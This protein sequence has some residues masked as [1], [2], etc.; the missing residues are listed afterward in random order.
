M[1]YEGSFIVIARNI[2]QPQLLRIL[3]YRWPF[4]VS[5]VYFKTT[6]CAWE[7]TSQ[8]TLLVNVVFFCSQN[9]R[10]K[11]LQNGLWY[12]VSVQCTRLWKR[13]CNISHIRVY[14]VCALLKSVMNVR[15]ST[16]NVILF[17]GLICAVCRVCDRSRL[18][19]LRRFL[20]LVEIRA[21]DEM[22]FC[23]HKMRCVQKFVSAAVPLQTQLCGSVSRNL[24]CYVWRKVVSLHSVRAYGIEE[25]YLH[26]FLIS[27]VGGGMDSFTRRLLYLQ[28]TGW[29]APGVC[30]DG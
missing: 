8:C 22:C 26:A 27:Q 21:Q 3:K 7:C 15:R 14:E 30:L 11:S 10:N 9:N 12:N 24:R 17:T 19:P 5:T 13:R 23:V 18:L 6:L 4:V 28:R 1:L 2:V 16:G 29:V 20:K 25:V